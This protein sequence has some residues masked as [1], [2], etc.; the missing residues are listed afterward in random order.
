MQRIQTIITLN[1]D[2]ARGTCRS[3]RILRDI[4]QTHINRGLSCTCQGSSQGHLREIDARVVVRNQHVILT[5]D[6]AG[7]R[8]GNVVRRIVRGVG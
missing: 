5:G 8:K 7:Y 4:A 3:R 2:A 1:A 6:Q